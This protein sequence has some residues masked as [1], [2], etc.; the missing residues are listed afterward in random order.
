MIEK[1]IWLMLVLPGPQGGC[2][3]NGHKIRVCMFPLQGNGDL[4]ALVGV[5][6]VLVV[7]DYS[8]RQ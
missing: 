6:Y 3:F 1:R 5:Y 8:R 2:H 7:R 4:E